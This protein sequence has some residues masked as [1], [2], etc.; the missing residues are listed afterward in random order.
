MVVD[1]LHAYRGTSGAE[2]AITIRNFLD[3]IGISPS[4][5]QL[6]IIATSASITNDDDGKGKEFLERFFGVDRADF[7]FVK[8]K[9][10]VIYYSYDLPWPHAG[11]G[12]RVQF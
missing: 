5:K 7:Q 4:S 3:R 2:V 10:K 11:A 9:P 6:R 1:E 12:V 8:G